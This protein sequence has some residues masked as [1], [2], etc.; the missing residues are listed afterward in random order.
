MEGDLLGLEPEPLLLAAPADLCVLAADEHLQVPIFTSD[1]IHAKKYLCA[2]TVSVRCSIFLRK[3]ASQK[4]LLFG[5]L[6]G[7]KLLKIPEE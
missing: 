7:R 3:F 2:L 1:K 5:I 6:I 4:C